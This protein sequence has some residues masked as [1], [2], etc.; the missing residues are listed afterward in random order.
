MWQ[1][2]L[3]LGA[4]AFLLGI[5]AL[6]LRKRCDKQLD[7]YVHPEIFL[8]E[9]KKK[10]TTSNQAAEILAINLDSKID[11]QRLRNIAILVALLNDLNERP[12]LAKYVKKVMESQ[13]DLTTASEKY[14]NYILEKTID[15][16]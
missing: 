10:V 3:V 9:I 11:H 14:K 15:W 5:K 2:V 13:V 16:E 4:I 7:T 8:S 12:K 6:I 1:Y